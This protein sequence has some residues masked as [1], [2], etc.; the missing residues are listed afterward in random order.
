MK[1]IKIE[2]DAPTY[3]YSLLFDLKIFKSLKLV[4]EWISGFQEKK[5]SHYYY[6]SILKDLQNHTML[7]VLK[8]ISL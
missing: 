7:I 6:N 1:N 5:M 4:S 3:I 8:S 2:I